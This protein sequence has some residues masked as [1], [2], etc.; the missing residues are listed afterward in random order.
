MA[1]SRAFRSFCVKRRSAAG[2]RGPSCSDL[3]SLIAPAPV[4]APARVRSRCG[5]VPVTVRAGLAGLVA[6][7]AL[8]GCGGGS[9]GS[10]ATHAASQQITAPAGAATA[11]TPSAAP[12]VAPTARLSRGPTGFSATGSMTAARGSHTATLLNDG[13]VLIVGGDAETGEVASAELYDPATGTF[14]P[15]GS[16]AQA[17][18]YQSATLLLDGRVLIAGGVDADG[19]AL[20]SAELYDPASG[21]FSP[22]GSMETTRKFNTATLLS[23]RRVLVAGGYDNDDTTLASAELYQP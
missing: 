8:A 6:T 18:T 23:D 15:T 20:A 9:L 12:T 16:M 1:S 11:N 4:A 19:D 2:R 10:S 21:T 14:S 17:R 5:W 13:R 22:T 7:V 3:A